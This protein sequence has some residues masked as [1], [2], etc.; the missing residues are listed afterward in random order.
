MQNIRIIAIH[1]IVWPLT[2]LFDKF[3][4][5]NDI[6]IQSKLSK[7]NNN[8]IVLINLLKVCVFKYI[9]SSTQ[10]IQTNIE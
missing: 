5:I 2:C 10:T 8:Y 7:Y 6:H 3:K 4:F 9:K 1:Y